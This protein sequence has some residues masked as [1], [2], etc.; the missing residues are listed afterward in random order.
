[1]YLRVSIW[2][3]FDETND[4]KLSTQYPGPKLKVLECKKIEEAFI[5]EGRLGQSNQITTR[6][7]YSQDDVKN[8]DVEIIRVKKV[9]VVL[10]G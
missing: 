2:K 1:M 3:Y 5:V 8:V 4:V 10:C 9:P 6:I 7:L